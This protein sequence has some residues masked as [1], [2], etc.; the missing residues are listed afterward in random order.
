MKVKVINMF[1]F[2]VYNPAPHQ[3]TWP[4][5]DICVN[6]KTLGEIVDAC[7]DE[8]CAADHGLEC[9]KGGTRW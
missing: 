3:W 7:F 2:S 1:M 5:W 6:G 9:G 4:D 8:A